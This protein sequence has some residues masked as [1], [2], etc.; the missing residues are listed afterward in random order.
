MATAKELLAQKL[1]QNTQK[2]Q[3]AQKDNIKELKEFRRNVPIEDISRSPYQPRKKFDEQEIKEL[4][5][6]IDEVGLLQP[7]TVRKLENF[8]FELIAGER[9]LRAHEVLKK[10]TIEAIIIDASDEEASLLTLAENLKRQD[11]TDFEIYIGL[12]GLDE[13]LKKN[14]QRLAKSLGLNREDMYKYLS[15]EKLPEVILNDLVDQPQLLG[16]TAATAFKK[17][18]ADHE[19]IIQRAEVALL[20]AWAKVK[21]GQLE[22][23]KAV[24]QATKY[25]D[26]NNTESPST[27]LVKKIEHAGKVAGNIKYNDKLL[28]VSL[29]IA[30]MDEAS[31]EKLENLLKEF[32]VKNNEV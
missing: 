16:R 27:S 9:R 10:S 19:D 26:Q 21:Q 15:F 14:K 22:Q 28:K 32:I 6:S 29:K 13:N 25:L 18:L 30:H 7:I 4:A 3:L 11:L 17:F 2:H 1:K 24:A 23:T 20:D 8:K 31:L 12:S 5:E